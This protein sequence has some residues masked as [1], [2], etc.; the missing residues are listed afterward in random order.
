M[1]RRNLELADIASMLVFLDVALDELDER[2]ARR[3]RRM[4]D[5]GLVDEAER[6]G[7]QAVAASAVGYP[8]ALAYVRGWSTP[9]ELR[10]SLERATRRYA[11]RQRTWFRS[12]RDAHW[13]APGA[14]DAVVREKLGWAA[15]PQ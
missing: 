14:V 5:T 2:I 15:K 7:S 10:D 8:Q 1:T 13:L 9:A 6:I 4:L 12:E 11:R 3:T